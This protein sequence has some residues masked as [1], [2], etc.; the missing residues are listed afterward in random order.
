MAC[1]ALEAPGAQAQICNA[2]N[3]QTKVMVNYA[4]SSS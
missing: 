4:S 1:Q 2:D 3:V